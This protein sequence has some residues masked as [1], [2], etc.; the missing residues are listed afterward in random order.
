M[1]GRIGPNGEDQPDRESYAKVLANLASVV[2]AVAVLGVVIVSTNRPARLNR[3]RGAEAAWAQSACGDADSHE[4]ASRPSPAPPPPAPAPAPEPPKLDRVAVGRA[5][6]AV[7][8]ASGDRERAEARADG[9]RARAREGHG[10]QA[11]A[12]SRSGRTL[13]LRVRDPSSRITQAAARGGFLKGERETLK[14]EIATL[15]AT[16]RPKAKVL[17]NKNPVAR[18]SDG[19]EHHFELR[20]NRISY[21][22][23][24]RL[25]MLVKTDAILRIKLS[26][27]ARIV[28]SRVGPVGPF[29]LEYSLARSLMGPT[30]D[31]MDRRKV[32]F[33]LRGWEIV[34][35]FDGRG[36]TYEAT[37]QP[38]SDYARTINRLS[39]LKATITMW[40]Y[41]DSFPLFRKLRDDLQARGY[42]VAA[43][44][45]PDG[46]AIRGSPS[47]SLSAGQ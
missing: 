28:E 6:E 47:G 41:P 26:E 31:L 39:P 10:S 20:R 5:E 12:D 15:A 22:D 32:S 11:A 13:S 1:A 42:L 7:E 16:A 27:G 46:M 4:A 9:G 40:V 2:A 43:R 34:P 17:S 25:L 38:V 18:P 33:D 36:E 19:D 30:V 8:A 35:E 24:D 23:L 37:H 45:L 44:P 29:S 21:I 3:R 14:G